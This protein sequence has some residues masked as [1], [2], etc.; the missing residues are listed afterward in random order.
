MNDPEGVHSSHKIKYDDG[1]TEWLDLSKY[2][3][4]L[5]SNCDGKGEDS[6]GKESVRSGTRDESTTVTSLANKDALFPKPLEL[7]AT[8]DEIVAADSFVD[9]E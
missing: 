9:N 4:R 1:D 8:R 3:F 6:K 7:A 5:F 2:S